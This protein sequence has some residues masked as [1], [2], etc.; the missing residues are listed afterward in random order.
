[1]EPLRIAFLVDS[2]PA[3]SETFVLNQ[4]TGLIDLGHHLDVY[5]AGP[6]RD[7]LAHPEVAEYGLETRVSHARPAR[8]PRFRALAAI[9]RHRASGARLTDAIG[10]I[11]GRLDKARLRLL[12]ACMARFPS[13]DYHVVQCHFAA[14][15]AL[16]VALKDLGVFRGT[17]VTM[18]H[19]YDL[20]EFERDPGSC[21]YLRDRG[22][23]FLAISAYS[24]ERLERLGFSPARI[25]EHPVGI[26][27]GEFPFRGPRVPSGAAVEILTV[28]RLVPQKGIADGLRALHELRARVPALAWQYTIV[29]GGPLLGELRL[30]A[31]SLGLRDRVRF[32]GE[33]DQPRV[34]EALQE[35][36][37]F[38]LPSLDEIL[39]LA[40]MEA[41]AVGLP[42]VASDVGAIGEIVEQEG[43]GFLVPAGDVAGLAAR[44][45]QLLASPEEWGRMGRVGRRRV[46]ERYDIRLLNRR[47]ETL[48]R[49]SLDARRPAERPRS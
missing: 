48:Y 45:G 36:D 47:L 33:A 26:D 16:G 38:L 7:Q 29:G 3:L 6:G 13:R 39:P 49:Q 30:L 5:A 24:R 34:A 31:Q 17:V 19:R 10:A 32:L 18:F 42:V 23:C 43:S 12:P 14:N 8:F 27:P 15:G 37:V 28:A 21:A 35:A 11:A 1:V 44:L 46:E 40:L 9:A 25:V 22:D 4:I 41:S 20:R 2:F